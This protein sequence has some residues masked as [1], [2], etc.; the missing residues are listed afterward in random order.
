MKKIHVI[1]LMTALFCLMGSLVSCDKLSIPGQESPEEKAYSVSKEA[2]DKLTEAYAAIDT[3]G[4]DIYNAW[5]SGIYDDDELS[6]SHL[7]SKTSLSVPELQDGLAYMILGDEYE[8]ATEEKKDEYRN[9]STFSTVLLIYEQDFAACTDLVNAAYKA[10]GKE[11][12]IKSILNDSK[13]LLK[14][15]STDYADYEHYPNLKNLYTSVNAFFEYCSSPEGSF[16]Q[17]KTTINDYR[18]EARKYINDLEFIFED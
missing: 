16:E 18:N 1:A 13:A 14:S 6:L 15:L 2:Y 9:E 12:E 8:T 4:S 11:D 3:Y 5:M 7:A 10:S 17:S